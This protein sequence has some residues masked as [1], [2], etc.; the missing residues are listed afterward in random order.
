M[1]S[2]STVESMLLRGLASVGQRTVADAIGGDETL[3][4]RFA[5]GTRGLHIGQIGPA[6]AAM[7]LKIVPA[8]SVNV[9]LS[10]L[11]AL[12]TLARKALGEE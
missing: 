1:A 10:E 6:F 4:S 3:V 2:D 5:S 8:D 9:P 11:Q 7:G 12:R